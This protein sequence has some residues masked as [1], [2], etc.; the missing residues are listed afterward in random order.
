VSASPPALAPCALAGPAGRLGILAALRFATVRSTLAVLTLIVS[1][2]SCPAAIDADSPEVRQSIERSV[3]Y[4]HEH[5]DEVKSWESGIVAYALIRAGESPDSSDVKTLLRRVVE[6]KLRGRGYGLDTPHQFYEAGT[7]MMLFEAA[8]AG[9]YRRELGLIAAFTTENQWPSGSWY[10]Y[11]QAEHGG[12]TSH[13]Q[14][15]VLG[16][17]AASRG[18]VRVARN[19]WTRVADWHLKTQLTDG[20]FAYHPGDV[21]QPTPGMTVNGVASLCVARLMLY[22]N[23]KYPPAFDDVKEEDTKASD[24]NEKATEPEEGKAAESKPGPA[25]P[26]SVLQPLDLSGTRVADRSRRAASPASGSSSQ[27][28]RINRGI[29]RGANWIRANYDQPVRQFPLYYLYGL[30]RMCAL[31]KIDNFDGH[32]WYSEQA[33]AIFRKQRSDGH[34]DG[35][36]GIRAETAFAV[37]FLSR[38]TSKLVAPQEP[39]FGGGLMIG[40]R[41]LPKNLAAIQTTGEGIKVRKLDAP[42]DKLLSELENPKSVEVESVQQ[43]IVDTVQIGD[44][45]KLVGQKERLKKLAR[46]PRPEVRRT[47]LWALGRCAT[48]RDALVLVKALDDPDIN[49]VVEANAALCWLSRRPNGFG[50]SLDPLADVPETA[51]DQQRHD[52]MEAWRK[53]ARRDWREWFNQVG[54]YSEHELPIDLP[55]TNP[56]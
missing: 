18:G 1:G 26:P 51:S 40:G 48:V 2:A 8:N 13:T 36:C 34:Y 52:A 44:R 10:Y 29:S 24:Q 7:D 35:E 53:Q 56:P 21:K 14:Y 37:L 31:A 15:A 9:R 32:D 6:E 30:E 45:Q 16:L 11:R 3:N 4:F 23:R 22:P 38:A 33:T 54:P 50:R 20:G 12:D 28:A 17:W 47:A 46:D 25:A 41:G 5:L 19:V 39:K 49:V 43:A 42:V 55:G 27:L